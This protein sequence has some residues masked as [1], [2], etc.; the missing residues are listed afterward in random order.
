MKRELIEI[1]ACPLCKEELELEILEEKGG[2][3]WM[4]CLS[5]AACAQSYPI[6]E[7]IPNLLPPDLRSEP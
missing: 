3:I 7:G 1:L 2:E 4:G 6:E 5:C